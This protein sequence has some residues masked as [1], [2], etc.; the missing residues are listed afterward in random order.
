MFKYPNI[1]PVLLSIGPIEIKWYSI[2]YIA[3]V[4]VGLVYLK[5]LDKKLRIFN[6]SDKQIDSLIAHV[7]LGIIIGGRLGYVLLYE[8][9][10]FFNDPLNV[11]NTLQGGMSFH[12][13]LV[14]YCLACYIFCKKNKC[15][16]IK[17]VDISSCLASIGIFFGRIANFIN[18][19]LYGRIT[20]SP[21][22]V[23]FPNGG[24]FPRHPSQIY[25][26]ILEGICLFLIQNYW[27]Y[28][29]KYK[30]PGFLSA[31]F[32]IFYGLSR[33]FVEFFREPDSHIGYIYNY[34]S[35]GQIYSMLMIGVGIYL[36]TYSKKSKF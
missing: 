6:F 4:L 20:D 15:Q 33:I 21:L 24:P 23:I 11:L 10:M 13:G 5:W 18:S 16:F 29:G 25:E 14:G 9:L 26:A 32:A 28:K 12:G 2:A 19:E 35:I 8:P 3:G 22:G 7:V 34:F 36:Y 27:L 17:L 1:D 31:S 30:Q